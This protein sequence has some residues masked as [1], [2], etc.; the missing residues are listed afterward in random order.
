V[1]NV[2]FQSLYADPGMSSLKHA[3][4]YFGK[5]RIPKNP[6]IYMSDEPNFV[7]YVMPVP[8]HAWGHVKALEAQGH[9]ELEEETGDL[10]RVREMIVT[11]LERDRAPLQYPAEHLD[12]LYHFLEITPGDK[13]LAEAFSHGVLFLAATALGGVA[14]GHGLPCVDNP[15]LFHIMN[16]GLR[17]IFQDLITRHGGFTPAEVEDLKAQYLGQRLIS[18]YLPSFEFR[19]FDDVFDAREKARDQILAL[20]ARVDQLASEMSALPWDRNY[21]AQVDAL[22]KRYVEPEVAELRKVA[23]VSLPRIARKMATAAMA[24]HLQT[25]LPE[26]IAPYVLGFSA[27]SV[28]NAIKEERE[29]A[30]TA[31]LKH[32]FSLLVQVP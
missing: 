18:L 2:I 22:V 29:R 20:H 24:V 21:G 30:K 8:E 1:Q 19:S 16:F 23:R 13:E 15:V 14:L 5:L 4:L 31:R 10:G 28:V 26:T 32:A 12:P 3:L 7:R 6:F 25:I 11:E 17:A 9:V 27:L